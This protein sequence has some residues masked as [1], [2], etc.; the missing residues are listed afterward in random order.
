MKTTMDENAIKV[1]EN[2]M[3]RM[4]A[5]YGLRLEKRPSPRSLT[6]SITASRP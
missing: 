2:L 1:R 3:R 4:A 5:R 6:R